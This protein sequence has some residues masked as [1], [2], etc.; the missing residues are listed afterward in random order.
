[1]FQKS[2]TQK[3]GDFSVDVSRYRQ[4]DLRDKNDKKRLKKKCRHFLSLS[5]RSPS[6]NSVVDCG[7]GSVVV[8][9]V[10]VAMWLRGCVVARLLVV[11]LWCSCV[12]V[13]LCVVACL[14]SC[15][16]VCSCV[17]VWFCVVACLCLCVVA[18][19]CS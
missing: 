7:V 2:H 19:L 17:N 11:C 9:S 12:N 1:M 4:C 8:D 10:G 5:T 15:V 16:V 3:A 14:C 13:W 6:L 18:C